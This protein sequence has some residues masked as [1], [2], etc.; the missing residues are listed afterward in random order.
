MTRRHSLWLTLLLT[1]AAT[2]W[3]Q[4]PA[5]PA[6]QPPVNWS[7]LSGEQQRL[8]ENFHDKWD[9]LPPGRQQA[10]S[11]GAQR[12]LKMSPEERDGAQNRYQNWQRLPPQ[13]QELIRQR[14]QRFQQLPPEQQSAVRQNYHAFSG[15]PPAQRQQ[16]RQRWLNATPQQRMQM[17]QNQRARRMQ[18]G[19]SFR[20]GRFPPP[21]EEREHR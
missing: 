20:G 9:S 11:N 14:W 13:Q 3:A 21:Q 15:L 4:E 2:A 6:A 18:R 19:G 8:L 7:S 1:A 5:P 17:L 12:W 10:L 16:L